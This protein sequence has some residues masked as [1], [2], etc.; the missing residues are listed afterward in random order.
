MRKCVLVLTVACTLSAQAPVQTRSR[1]S[2]TQQ[3][4][5]SPLETPVATFHGTLKSV[6]KKELVLEVQNEHEV[7]FA[8]SHKTKFL[9]EKK[10]IKAADI[11]SGAVLSV[12]GKRDIL[13]N[14][15]A[16]VVRLE[17]DAKP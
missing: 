4:G 12:D 7:A 6:S 3:S 15:E 10:S 16:V 9:K 13:G 17:P 2:G 5:V 8:I 14:T 11:P 1:R